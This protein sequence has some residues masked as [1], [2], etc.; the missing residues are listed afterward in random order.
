MYDQ[1]FGF[2]EPPFSVTPDPRFCYT[3][4]VYQE[5]FATL[6]YG[7]ETRKGFIVITGEAGT[8]KTTLLRK[9]MRN[10]E[11]TVHTAF[12]FNPH[13]DLNELLRL[14]LHDLGIESSTEDR[15]TM[16][17]QLN[18]YLI[19]QL[20]KDHVVSLLIDEAQ[21][22][23]DEMLEELRLLS[24]LETDREKLIQIVLMGQP[25]LERSLDRR[26][27][28]QLKQRVAMR[29]RLTALGNDEVGLYIEAR[30]QV[31][32]Y[33]GKGLFD[34]EA[35]KKVAAYSK[36][37]PR[38]INV[39]CDNA[40]LIAYAG[41]KT[42]VGGEI[43]DEAARDLQLE[44][45]V[46]AKTTAAAT[47][48]VIPDKRADWAQAPLSKA[49]EDLAVDEPWLP[50]LEEFAAGIK[51]QPVP[52]HDRRNV[53]GVAIGTLTALVILAG[54]GVAFYS[55]QS[56]LLETWRVSIE[57]FVGVRWEPRLESP[58][59]LPL[60]TVN[61][62]SFSL[63]VRRAS[64]LILDNYSQNGRA[65]PKSE[66][67]R[68][69]TILPEA[70][71]RSEKGETAPHAKPQRAEPSSADVKPAQ[72]DSAKAK[73]RQRSPVSGTF[74]VVGVSFVRDQ[75]RADANIT[76]TLA[77]GSRIRIQSKTGDYFRVRSLDKEP[78]S[79]YVH[80]ED[81]FFKPT[82]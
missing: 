8:G 18:E 76:G 15:L 27:L 31:A 9:F 35:V 37:V 80:R 23:S 36:G 61:E 56:R 55:K 51:K 5:A 29:C 79:G 7:I 60:Q 4:S 46:K 43:I 14:I 72:P 33:S 49:H 54:T 6:R 74:N 13:V 53:T 48:F 78:I 21:N 52:Q 69:G 71:G 17:A 82:K 41:S 77:P 68:S 65:V 63:P 2:L 24:N 58:T 75:P 16:M 59:K 64:E 50:D 62:T 25:E 11:S 67:R 57:D 42:K 19:E 38:L 81:A 22:L 44:H 45:P 39:L 70:E 1:H 40:L 28:R 66:S 32:G 73:A 10:V 34:A 20:R 47:S 3:N 26:Q 30:L 12:I